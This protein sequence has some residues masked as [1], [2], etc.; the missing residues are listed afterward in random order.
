MSLLSAISITKTFNSSFEALKNVSLR[1]EEGE[2]VGI[3]GES[4]SGKSTLAQIVGGLMKPDSGTVL[5]NDRD[6]S[7]LSHAEK[8]DYRHGVQFI[9]QDPKASMNPYFSLYRV[10]EEPLLVNYKLSKAE[11]RK[12]IEELVAKLSLDVDI[13]FRHPGEISG[14]QAQRI[15]IAR[16][17]LLES[18]VIIADECVSSLDLSVQAQIMN[19]LRKIRAERKTSFLFISHDIELVCYFC[20]RIYV[21]LH[22]RIV[23]EIESQRAQ[24][25]KSEYTRLLLGSGKSL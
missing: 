17:L 24:E 25:A 4:G 14:G 18:R 23:E 6:I 11:R 20:S 19:L 7:T 22:G 21:M 3:V 1:L 15:A 10:L 2:S 12:R 13:L 16:C 8:L 9:F 5:Y